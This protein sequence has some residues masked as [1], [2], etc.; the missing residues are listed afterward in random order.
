MN[1]TIAPLIWPLLAGA[2]CCFQ[3]EADSTTDLGAL[4]Q[5]GPTSPPAINPA[6]NQSN[7]A[8]AGLPTSASYTTGTTPLENPG[9]GP[10]GFWDRDSLTGG[11]SGLR[12]T[13]ADDGFVFTPTDISEV[14][15]NPSGGKARG[16]TVDGL[17]DAVVDFDLEKMTGGDV[18]GLTIHGDAEYI[19]GEPLSTHFIGDF[20]GTSNIADFNSVRLQ[21]LWLQQM[22]WD[23]K[24]SVKVGNIS[25]D[26]EFFQS[27]TAGLFINSTFGAFSLIANNIPNAPLYPVASPGLRL[28]V[29]PDPRYYA[30]AGVFGM[31]NSSNL[32]TNNQHGTRFA[33]TASSGVLIMSEAGYLLNQGPKD[34]G[35]QGTYR[36]GSFVH[37]ANY[38]TWTSRAGNDIDNQPPHSAGA[39]YGVYAVMDQQLYSKGD[40]SVSFFV[41]SGGAPSNVNFVDWYVD[42]GLNFSGFVAGRKLDVAGIAVAR[43]HVSGDFSDAENFEG[44]PGYTAETVLE[45][46]YKAQLAPWWSVQPDFQYIIT[47]SGQAGSHNATV[48]GLRT[49]VAF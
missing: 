24:L 29:N 5:H 40:E 2:T 32:A 37:T 15:G 3:L 14:F 27:S 21:E 4:Q 47:P 36:L 13:L 6:N 10:T 33:L 41:R 34:T 20:S 49:T 22:L 38:D 28:L 35:L 17:F 45:A 23:N 16:V 7:A 31:D 39:N 26:S 18:K 19:Y 46:T 30:M 42:G 48:I 25:V 12:K 11:W 43:S 9:S 1:R 8:P 44:E